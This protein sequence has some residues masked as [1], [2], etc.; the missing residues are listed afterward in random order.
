MPLLNAL[1]RWPLGIAMLAS[2]AGCADLALSKPFAW[3]GLDPQR[4]RVNPPPGSTVVLAITHA[5][6]IGAHRAPFDAAADRVLAVLPQQPGLIGYSVRSRLIGH[7][8][9][10]ATIWADEAAMTAFVR[11]PEHMAAA[12][13]GAIALK[14]IEYRRVELPLTELPISWG[15]ALA[16]LAKPQL[17]TAARQSAETR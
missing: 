9:W 15:R 5:E 3:P 10:T 7:E 2:L 8:V 4:S 6:L 13:D 12:R 17:A 14:T 16:E 1:T 11:S